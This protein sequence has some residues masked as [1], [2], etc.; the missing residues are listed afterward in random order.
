MVCELTSLCKY[1]SGT[2]ERRIVQEHTVISLNFSYVG[3]QSPKL[4]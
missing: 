4:M 1:C 3:T 2:C